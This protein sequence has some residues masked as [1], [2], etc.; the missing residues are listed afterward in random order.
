MTNIKSV[1]AFVCLSSLLAIAGSS[2]ACSVQSGEESVQPRVETINR[3][4][5]ALSTG[6]LKWVNGTYGEGCTNR[7][8]AWSAHIGADTSDMTN[9]ALSVVKNDTGC[10]LTVTDLEADALYTG[11]R[12]I[13]LTA[14]YALTAS[15]FA[16]GAGP[17]AFYGNAELGSV[18]YASDFTMTI[19]FS[20]D[21]ADASDSK[22][23]SY[24]SQTSTVSESQ[25]VAPAYTTDFTDMQI[26]TDS[27]AYVQSTSGSAALNLAMGAR[28]GEKYVITSDQSLGSSFAAIDSAYG[29]AGTPAT[30]GASIDASEFGLDGGSVHLPAV[31]NLIISHTESGVAAYEV[32]RV[33][34]NAP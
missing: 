13:D 7:S 20:D 5:Q 1:R 3:T 25:V 4:H 22:G 14:S 16:N 33:T 11:S 12:P 34:F 21:L 32:I 31:R 10:V 26:Q 23:S 24:A 17:I 29:G 6:A 30:L 8:G 15:A 19:L 2:F 9:T 28:S 27:N 18:D